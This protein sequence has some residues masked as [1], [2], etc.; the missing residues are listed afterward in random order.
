MWNLLDWPAAVFPIGL[1][2]GE[3]DDVR[4]PDPRNEDEAHLYK[5][6]KFARDSCRRYGGLMDR[7]GKDSYRIAHLFTARGPQMAGRKAAGSS[8]GDRRGPAYL[9]GD[10]GDRGSTE[11]KP[12]ITVHTLDGYLARHRQEGYWTHKRSVESQMDQTSDVPSLQCSYNT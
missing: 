11:T 3:E 12:Y 2:V 5:T 7:L 9:D 4:M 8:R 10:V 1:T 6:C